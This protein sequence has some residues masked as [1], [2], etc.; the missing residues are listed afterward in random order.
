[1]L[2][3]NKDH[4]APGGHKVPMDPKGWMALKVIKGFKVAKELKDLKV[5]RV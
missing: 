4:R 3:A 1:M 5:Y 2:K